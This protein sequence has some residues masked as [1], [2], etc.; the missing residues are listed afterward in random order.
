MLQQT[1]TLTHPDHRVAN[2]LYIYSMYHHRHQQQHPPD[3]HYIIPLFLLNPPARRF[4][5]HIFFPYFFA[6]IKHSLIVV[7]AVSSYVVIFSVQV[8]AAW[9]VHTTPA[10]ACKHWANQPL[11]ST[12]TTSSTT[13]STTATPQMH[14]LA[15]NN[16][17]NDAASD[18]W[19]S[20]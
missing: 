19:F 20:L 17:N 4:I 16:N 10:D 9:Y 6:C 11:D 15:L 1:K 2:I 12:T 14:T 18:V 5:P 13:N 8:V 7:A 3:C